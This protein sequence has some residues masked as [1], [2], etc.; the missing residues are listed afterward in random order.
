MFVKF[1]SDHKIIPEIV[2]KMGSA[3]NKQ[4]PGLRTS[5]VEIPYYLVGLKFEIV[6]KWYTI[7]GLLQIHI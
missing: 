5:L 3:D 1:K 6:F 7:V 2:S 4:N